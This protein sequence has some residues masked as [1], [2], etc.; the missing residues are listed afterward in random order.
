VYVVVIVDSRRDMGADGVIETPLGQYDAYQVK[1][2]SGRPNLT[3]D[4]LST[5]NLECL[6]WQHPHGASS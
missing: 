4:E 6:S 2:R 3:W 1:F 5:F